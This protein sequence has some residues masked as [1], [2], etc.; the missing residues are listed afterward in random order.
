MAERTAVLPTCATCG[1]EVRHAPTFHVGLA[2][3]CVGCAADGPCTCSYD[4]EPVGHDDVRAA[5]PEAD[6]RR[7]IAVGVGG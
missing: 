6:S 3:C 7:R 4:D 2:F 5:V 1:L